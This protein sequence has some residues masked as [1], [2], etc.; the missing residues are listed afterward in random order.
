MG[1]IN[2]IMPSDE[3]QRLIQKALENYSNRVKKESKNDNSRPYD[4][5]VAEIV[6]DVIFQCR[7]IVAHQFKQ[8]QLT[9]K[10]EEDDK[11]VALYDDEQSLQSDVNI[12]YQNLE[13]K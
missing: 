8:S 7:N 11:F 9:D 6:Q 13:G 12:D 1:T 3:V 4:R 5:Q 10:R 2:R